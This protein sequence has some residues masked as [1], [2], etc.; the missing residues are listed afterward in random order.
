VH[1][2]SRQLCW[3]GLCGTKDPKYAAGQARENLRST[4]S[5]RRKRT[6][7]IAAANNGGQRPER[8]R[9]RSGDRRRFCL[10]DLASAG[11]IGI[12]RA[13]GRSSLIALPIPRD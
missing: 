13:A 1:R 12:D 8:R 3:R 4:F 9:A 7:V 5:G 6:T 10:L 2:F 11:S